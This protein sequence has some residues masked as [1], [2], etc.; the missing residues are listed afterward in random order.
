MC[1]VPVH[2][3]DGYLSRLIRKGFRV[4][5]CEQTEDPAEARKRGGKALVTREVVRIVT[6]GTIT[7]EALLDSRRHNY[8]AALADSGGALGLAWLDVSTGEFCVQPTDDAHLTAALARLDPGE[9]LVPE[10]LLQR[11]ELFRNA[12]RMEVGTDAETLEP[13]R[14]RSG[15]PSARSALRRQ[16]PGWFR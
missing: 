6:R 13:V 4:A 12:W 16:G 1:G 8:L 14:Q 15:A 7:E 2:A 5:V 9:L 11:T 10:R 3:A